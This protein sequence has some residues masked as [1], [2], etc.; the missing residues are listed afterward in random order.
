MDDTNCDPEKR[1]EGVRAC[2][3]AAPPPCAAAWRTSPW[4]PVSWSSD[5]HC[6][7]PTCSQ[8]C[9]GVSEVL[10]SYPT[11]VNV[12]FRFIAATFKNSENSIHVNR[13]IAATFTNS[14]NSIHVKRNDEVRSY[15]SIDMI[16]S[17]LSISL[18]TDV[19]MPPQCSAS[20]EKGS[21][22][23]K[24]F[25]SDDSG[26]V[27]LDRCDGTS[28]PYTFQDCNDISCADAG[29]SLILYT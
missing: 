12:I 15:P 16:Q 26:R 28:I 19:C 13:F 25:C 1:Y 23:R 3:G 7:V 10:S 29:Q 8:Y 11:Q 9:T 2:E 5:R 20:C 4:G 17:D 27:P 24:V 21:Q 14:E 18:E 22:T 6:A